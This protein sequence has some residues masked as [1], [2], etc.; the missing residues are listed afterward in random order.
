MLHA[1]DNDD[2]DRRNDDNTFSNEEINK[3]KRS[4]IS[5]NKLNLRQ[6]CGESEIIIDFQKERVHNL[7]FIVYNKCNEPIIQFKISIKIEDDL[8][9]DNTF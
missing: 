8:K 5:G 3:C 1:R 6:Q 2:G 7:L 9:A 4:E